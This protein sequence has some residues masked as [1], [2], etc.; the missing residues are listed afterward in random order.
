MSG[1]K[2]G[3]FAV[4]FFLF[5]FSVSSYAGEKVTRH[6]SAGV[7]YALYGMRDLGLSPLHYDGDHIF[8]TT[9]LQRHTGKAISIAEVSFMNGRISPD[10][11][12]LL[13]TAEMKS[14]KLYIHY[15][16]YRYTGSILNNARL[17]L[18]GSTLLHSASYRHNLFINSSINLNTINSLNLSGMISL[19]FAVNEREHLL[20]LHLQAPVAAFIVRPSYAYIKPSGF[21][22]HSSGGLESIFRSIE[23]ATVDR[24]FSLNSGVSLKYSLRNNSALRICYRWEYMEHSGDNPFNSA[25]HGIV[26]QTIFTL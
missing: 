24:F 22:D 8:L 26:L 9:S 19:P 1:Y 21:L 4:F 10:I 15:S 3:F 18:G 16:Y 7:G 13:T 20:E 11:N 6:V 14:M 5:S 23:V 2:T 12:P 17:Y 25:T